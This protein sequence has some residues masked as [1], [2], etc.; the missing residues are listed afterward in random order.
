MTRYREILRFKLA[1]SYDIHAPE[2]DEDESGRSRGHFGA[3]DIELDVTPVQYVAFFLRNRF[4]VDAGVWDKANYDL[5]LSDHRGDS[6]KISYRYTR[7]L[8]EEINLSLHAVLTASVSLSYI[9]KRNDFDHENVDNTF[10]FTYQRQCWSLGLSYSAT[11]QDRS[12]ALLFSLNGLGGAG[13]MPPDAWGQAQGLF[14]QQLPTSSLRRP[15]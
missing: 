9:L 6:A 10:T 4:D 5:A 8:L 12:L 15:Q 11:T 1:Q 3:L 13:Q 14:P 7:D 2:R